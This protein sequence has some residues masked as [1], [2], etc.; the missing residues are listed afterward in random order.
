M[1]TEAPQTMISNQQDKIS[2]NDITKNIKPDVVEDNINVI[3]YNLEDFDKLNRKQ[4]VKL[5]ADKKVKHYNKNIPNDEK[6]K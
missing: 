1:N 5:F 6:S 2:F 3:N 4:K